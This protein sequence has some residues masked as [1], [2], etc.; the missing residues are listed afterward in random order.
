MADDTAGPAATADE[1]DDT[2]T[3]TDD[4]G[5]DG[6]GEGLSDEV[7]AILAKER[8]AAREADKRAKSAEARIKEFEDKDKSESEKLAEKAALAEK[9][10][11]DARTELLRLKVGGKKGLAPE[12]AERLVGS[13]EE[14]MAADADRLLEA[15]KAKPAAGSFDGGA[16]SPAPGGRSMNDLIRQAAGRT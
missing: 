11:A 1:P 13:T 9:D 14:E 12:L 10:A 4:G 16:R 8:K 5:G 7:K 2:T 6:G 3:T 15:I